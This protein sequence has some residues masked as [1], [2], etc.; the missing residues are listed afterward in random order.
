MKR[1]GITKDADLARMAHVSPSEISRIISGGNRNPGIAKLQA[2]ADALSITIAQLL[3][4]PSAQE[5]QAEGLTQEFKEIREH[6]GHI[7]QII[8]ET[9][10]VEIPVYASVPAG[11][12]ETATGEIID[13]IRLRP[14]QIAIRVS[15]DSMVG[16]GINHRDIIVLDTEQREPRNGQIAVVRLQK[17][18]EVTI[19]QFFRENDH[20]RLEPAN[21]KFKAILAQD[22]EV[23]GVVTLSM[24]KFG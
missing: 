8:G 22:V 23:L 10:E 24:R 9:P 4:E 18:G 12:P 1:R 13:R 15:G 11:L 17:T 16:L 7:G 19:K 6:L 21:S 20:V 2:I 3:T 5:K 14:G